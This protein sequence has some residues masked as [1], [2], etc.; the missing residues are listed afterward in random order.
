MSVCLAGALL[1]GLALTPAIG[2]NEET[3]TR[4]QAVELA[5]KRLREQLRSLTVEIEVREVDAVEWSGAQLSCQPGDEIDAGVTYPGYRILLLTEDREFPVHVGAGRAVI[6]PESV[7]EAG[8]SLP[9]NDTQ[10]QLVEK[11]TLDLEERLD[12]TRGEIDLLGIRLVTWPDS[13]LGCPRPGINYTQA[14]REGYQILLSVAGRRYAYHSGLLG[15]PFYCE[16]P[17]EPVAVEPGSG[18]DDNRH[19]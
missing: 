2:G 16:H 9:R 12:I 5:I 19:R 13:S 8:M 14:T 3:V 10:R 1:V 11:A 4:D 17:T 7:E 15:A 18:I 6:C